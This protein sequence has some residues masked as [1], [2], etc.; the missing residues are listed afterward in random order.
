MFVNLGG[1]NKEELG[2]LEMGTDFEGMSAIVSTSL[3]GC[4]PLCC[5]YTNLKIIK[6]EAATVVIG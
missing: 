6:L 1:S 2:G 3:W 5:K 4:F